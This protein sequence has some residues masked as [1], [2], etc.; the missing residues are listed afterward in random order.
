MNYT[1]TWTDGHGTVEYF[2]GLDLHDVTLAGESL[3][4]CIPKPL[5]RGCLS[6]ETVLSVWNSNSSAPAVSSRP[7]GRWCSAE[8]RSTARSC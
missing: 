2:T 5:R 3:G 7:A 6:T 1:D 4:G 8:E